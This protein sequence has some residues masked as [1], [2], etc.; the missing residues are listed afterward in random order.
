MTEEKKE[1]PSN[2]I[3]KRDKRQAEAKAPAP[4]REQK[5]KPKK[6][7]PVKE[8]RIEELKRPVVKSRVKKPS[9]FDKV[10]D[11]FINT[12]GNSVGHYVVWEV[13]IPALKDTAG[14]MVIQAVEMLLHG[15]TSG[16]SSR[17]TSASTRVSYQNYYRAP[18]RK[19]NQQ[20]PQLR[21]PG[22]RTRLEAVIFDY[23]EEAEIVLDWMMECIEMYGHVTVADFYETAGLINYSEHTDNSWGWYSMG[24]SR[25]VRTR[26]GFQII[27]PSPSRLE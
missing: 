13:L 20:D 10:K 23:E 7:T 4:M 6:E 3:K 17:K 5:P 21:S 11:T 9:F 8:T 19:P 25:I 18:I 14:D 26:D 2:E 16:R 1:L 12:D 15:K 24:R 27:F 22:L